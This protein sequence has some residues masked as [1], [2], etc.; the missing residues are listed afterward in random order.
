VNAYVS[1]IG[2]VFATVW[3]GGSSAAERSPQHS[4]AV[5]SAYRSNAG[6]LQ[7]SRTRATTTFGASSMSA[8]SGVPGSYST[9]V[10]TNTFVHDK[11]EVFE[12]S[13]AKYNESES[14]L[15]PA[16]YAHQQDYATSPVPLQVIV[17]TTDS[18]A[19]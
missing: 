10:G 13:E 6:P 16:P 8:S 3:A 11:D 9:R 12:I 19:V 15:G 17:E 14:G 2:V 1:C 18:R 5:S 4:Y 7:F